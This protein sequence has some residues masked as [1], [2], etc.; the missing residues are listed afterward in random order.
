MLALQRNHRPWHRYHVLLAVGMAVVCALI[1]SNAWDDLIRLSIHDEESSHVL[2]VPVVVAWLIW[3]RQPHGGGSCAPCGRLI[4]T[5]F[6]AVGWCLWSVGYRYQIQSFWH[7]GAVMFTVGGVLSVLGV[8]ALLSF[9]PAFA[10]LVFAIPI[11]STGRQFVALPLQRMTGLAAQ[12]TA[13]LVGMSVNLHGNL[14]EVNGTEV[15]IAEACNGMR[16]IFTLF[17]A[18]YT[19]AFVTPLRPYVRFIIL[20]CSPVVAVAANV[21]RLVP[22]VWMFGHVNSGLAEGF[23]DASGWVM[24]VLAFLALRGTVGVLRWAMLPV[25]PFRLIGT[26]Q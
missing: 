10:V 16:M 22:T 19:F 3:M 9:L 25:A 5:L 20:V 11:P 21:L 2:L 26:A 6:L 23:H 24:L 18:C 8:E 7:F 17:L 15:A 4:G 14:M 1:T 12:A 13:D